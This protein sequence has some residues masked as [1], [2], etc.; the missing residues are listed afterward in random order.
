LIPSQEGRNSQSEFAKSKGFNVLR[1]TD[2]EVL[3]RGDY[4]MNKIKEYIQG[5]ES[6]L[7]SFNDGHT[8]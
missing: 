5:Y 8:P 2:G 3:G 4:V 1:F 6:L 7:V